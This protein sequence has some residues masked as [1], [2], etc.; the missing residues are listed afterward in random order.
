VVD[1]APEA[2]VAGSVSPWDPE[3]ISEFQRD[4]GKELAKRQTPPY[5]A[6]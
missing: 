5:E 4:A 1:K 3:G 6:G 2:V